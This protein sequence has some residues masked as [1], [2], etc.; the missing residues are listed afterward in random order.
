VAKYDKKSWG[1]MS[2]MALVVILYGIVSVSI[3]MGTA[4]KCGNLNAD[5]HWNIVPPGWEC[6]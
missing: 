6:R 1:L 5:K 2:W 4:D 3:G